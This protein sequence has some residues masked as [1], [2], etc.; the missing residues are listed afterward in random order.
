LKAAPLPGDYRTYAVGS[1]LLITRAEYFAFLRDALHKHDTLYA[2]AATRPDAEPLAG[3]GLTFA[4]ATPL[5][6]WVVRRYRRGGAIASFLG[7]RYVRA[8]EPR[9]IHE[10]RVSAAARTRGVRTPAVVAAAVYASGAFYRADLITEYVSPSADLAQLGFGKAEHPAEV[11][12]AAWRAAG[13]LVRELAGWGLAHADLNLKNVLIHFAAAP[14]A[15]VLD[16]DRAELR[17]RV[18]AAPLWARLQRS[19]QKWERLTGRRLEPA[20]RAALEAGYGG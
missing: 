16:L 13:A 3:R 5:G 20:E 15:W 6:P 8:G 2:F 14:E 12:T 11:R 7:D 1:T 4:V 10:L 9:A 19:L 18:S 17:P